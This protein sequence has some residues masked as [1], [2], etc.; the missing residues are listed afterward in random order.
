MHVTPCQSPAVTTSLRAKVLLSPV[1]L[2][3]MLSTVYTQMI[4]MLV[5]FFATTP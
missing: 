4:D 2:L 1:H 5:S 3:Y